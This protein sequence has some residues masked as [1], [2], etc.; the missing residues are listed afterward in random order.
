MQKPFRREFLA[1]NVLLLQNLLHDRLR[2]VR[3]IDG[4]PGRIADPIRKS[5]QDP[6]TTGMK[7]RHPDILGASANDRIH[8]LPHLARRLV[9]K[10]DR[11]DAP[12]RNVHFVYQVGD[13]LRQHTRLSAT[14][15]REDQHRSFRCC[16]A[17]LLLFVQLCH[18]PLSLLYRHDPLRVSCQVACGILKPL[19]G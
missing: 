4:K 3:I 7:G 8:A 17:C 9:R 12:G 6:H 2:I 5:P 14:R 19:R 15:A 18:F 1:V 11:H 13:A 16:N 10:G